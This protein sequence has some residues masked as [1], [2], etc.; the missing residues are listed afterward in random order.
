MEI[1][2]W[3]PTELLHSEST[4][5]CVGGGLGTIEPGCRKEECRG[6]KERQI[7]RGATLACRVLEIL[8]GRRSLSVFVG[9][10]GSWPKNVS[11][12]QEGFNS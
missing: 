7:Q 9:L 10:I 11:S 6:Q 5:G 12:F 8:R 2:L 4:S 1:L 3:Q